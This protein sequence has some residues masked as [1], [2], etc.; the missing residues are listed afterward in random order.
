M[1]AAAV[2]LFLPG[3]LLLWW[4]GSTLRDAL[5]RRGLPRVLR[6]VAGVGTLGCA[7]LAVS[8]LWS[9]AQYGVV[10]LPVAALVVAAVLN[11]VLLGVAAVVDHGR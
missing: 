2:L 8:P 6:L 5:A 1:S 7:V 4:G 9:E 3:V 10:L 11:A